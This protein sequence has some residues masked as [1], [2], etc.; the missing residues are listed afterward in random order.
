MAI[1]RDATECRGRKLRKSV[2]SVE[3]L[4]MTGLYV[5]R[6]YQRIVIN[7]TKFVNRSPFKKYIDTS[8][9]KL[10]KRLNDKAIECYEDEKKRR[11]RDGQHFERHSI[12]P[13]QRS[14]GRFVAGIPRREIRQQ[15]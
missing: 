7:A 11:R 12:N 6:Q 3:S 10:E 4:V 14:C 8:L 2:K 1:I 5:R 15:T 9:I 13:K